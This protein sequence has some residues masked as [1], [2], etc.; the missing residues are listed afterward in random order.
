MVPE[1]LRAALRRAEAD[2]AP[3]IVQIPAMNR[4]LDLDRMREMRELLKEG[5]LIEA[6]Q[7][8]SEVFGM[9]SARAQEA[10]EN[11]AA[12]KPTIVYQ[13]DSQTSYT[14]RK[15]VQIVVPRKTSRR[16]I[17]VV[18]CLVALTVMLIFMGTLL[19]FLMAILAGLLGLAQ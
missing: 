9:D 16:I 8:Y 17:Q 5:R 12:G 14:A 6:A 3:Q 15:P 1:Y 7:V 19:P 2:Q 4:P 11:L 13:T 10:V 18:G